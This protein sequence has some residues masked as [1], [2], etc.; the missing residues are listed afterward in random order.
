MKKLILLLPLAFFAC[1]NPS[2]E[3]PQTSET[4]GTAAQ[5]GYE[6]FGDSTL[7]LEG[8]IDTDELL[9]Q[10]ESTDSVMV[11]VEGSV[12][13]VCQKKGCWME[14]QL[15]DGRNMTVRFKDYEFFVPMNSTGK[16]AVVEGVAKVETQDVNWLKHKASDAGKTQEEI[17]AITEPIT[18]VTFMANGVIIKG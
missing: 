6:V 9:A 14:M 3:T 8:A 18:E 13:D 17:D 15:A 5:T 4:P 1:N 11:K 7:T 12:V 10:L 2:E 16:T